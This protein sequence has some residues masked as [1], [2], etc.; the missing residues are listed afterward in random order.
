MKSNR[1]RSALGRVAELAGDADPPA[2]THL[3]DAA[4]EQAALRRIAAIAAAGEPPEALFAAVTEEASALLDGVLMS[5]ARYEHGGTE[6]VILAHTGDHLFVGEWLP[7]EN[8]NTISAQMWKMRRPGR[9]DDFT[10]VAG[11]KPAGFDRRGVRAYVAVPVIVDGQLW[12]CLTAASRT[13]PLPALTEDRLTVFAEI[14]ST[15]I[16][17]AA[18][19]ASVRVLAD[20]QAALLRVAALVAQGAQEA[21]IFDAVAVEASSLIAGETTT[22]L[23][24]EGKRTFTVL[25]TRNGPARP[26]TRFTVPVDDAGTLAEMLR[27]RKQSR[28]DRDDAV[29]DQSFS[30]KE[31]AVGSSVSVPIIVQ[32][33]LWGALG[34]LNEGGRLPA[35]TEARMAKFSELVASAL[36]NVQARTELERFG[37][38]QAALR[39]V[40]ELAASGVSY[41]SV[42][43][44]V[45]V[46]A[47]LLF[48]EA[49]VSVGQY[50]SSGTWRRIDVAGGTRDYPPPPDPPSGEDDVARKVLATGRPVRRLA[51]GSST[52]GHFDSGSLLW[53][54]GGSASRRGADVGS[55]DRD[56]GAATAALRNGGPV[57]AV[58]A[59]RRDC[60]HRC[61]VA[62]HPRPPRAGP[63][64]VAE[65]SRAHCSR[66]P[67]RRGLRRRRDRSVEHSRA[68]DDWSVPLRR[69][70]SCHVG[71]RMP[72]LRPSRDAARGQPQRRTEPADHGPVPDLVRNPVRAPHALFRAR[73][74]S[75]RTHRH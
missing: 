43:R 46:E 66:R 12:G 21:A 39:R 25:A 41:A 24:Y 49:V 69:R 31:F 7:G 42:L 10:K 65:G 27:T 68:D 57:G 3:G 53:G 15:A 48:D 61:P 36:A 4:E 63:G 14:V 9:V 72:L 47:A 71:G 8:P 75:G 29:A 30:N 6:Q 64:G 38:E 34:A 37:E 58:R 60:G 19:R 16:V 2:G 59:R 62:R 73:R 28:R 55:P 18:A 23:R 45:V 32:G 20:E 22:L 70:W 5:I 51:E 52:V 35:E 67:S 56:R 40:A 1:E 17:S 33:R 13:G 11:A 74:S 44:A 54:S 26:G 50:G